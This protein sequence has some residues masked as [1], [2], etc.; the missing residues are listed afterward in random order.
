MKPPTGSRTA[1]HF[2]AMAGLRHAELINARIAQGASILYDPWQAALAKAKIGMRKF[3][4]LA[5]K[6][7]YEHCFM[8]TFRENFVLGDGRKPVDP[9]AWVNS[10]SAQQMAKGLRNY[11]WASLG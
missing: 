3:V 1:E 11:R 4:K 7:A 9:S 6:I 10:L 5:D 8:A 2:G